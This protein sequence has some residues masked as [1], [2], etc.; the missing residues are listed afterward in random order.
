M[1]TSTSVPPRALFTA[2]VDDAAVFPPA[3]APLVVALARHRAHRAAAYADLVGPLLLPPAL[4]D[5]LVARVAEE[6]WPQPLAVG[7]AARPGTPTSQVAAAVETLT[8]TPGV[9]LVGVEIGWHAAWR[10]PHLTAHPVVLEIPRGDDRLRALDDVAASGDDGLDV[11]AKLRTGA[12]PT[13]PWPHE[14]E[15]AQF[16]HDAVTRDVPFKLTGGLHHAVRGEYPATPG[17]E[18]EPMH[19]VLNVIAA[20]A[21]ARTGAD[22]DALAALLAE[23]DSARL[24]DLVGGLDD[25]ASRDVRRSLTAYGC[26]EVTDPVTELDDLDLL[27]ETTA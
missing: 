4:V 11:R 10:E 3:E 8:T 7:L 22:V 5:E 21:A 6:P 12:T 15:V 24:T 26:C 20:V 23:R 17:A 9:E 1:P 2:L 27:E 18:P 14:R 19:G 25:E 13:W 16:L